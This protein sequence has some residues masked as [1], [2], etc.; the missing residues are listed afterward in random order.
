MAATPMDAPEISVPAQWPSDRPL[1]AGDVLTCEISASYW[2]YTAQALRTYAVG[3]EP[4][5][6]HRELHAVA[7]AA[8][9]AVSGR[10]RAGATAAELVGSP[11]SPTSPSRRG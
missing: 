7:E 1:A 6:L 4:S 3:A 11:P 2:E 10:L 8:F 9:D 5:A